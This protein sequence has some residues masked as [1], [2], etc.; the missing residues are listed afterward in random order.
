LDKAWR[1]GRLLNC[2]DVHLLAVVPFD[3]WANFKEGSNANKVLVLARSWF[4]AAS[5]DH[6][7]L[8]AIAFDAD[9]G[10]FPNL[11][12]LFLG[13]KTCTSR[14]IHLLLGVQDDVPKTCKFGGLSS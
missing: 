8:H 3:L 12:Q 1:N 10:F 4:L 14:F 11:P 5:A 9:A 2:C 6:M 7:H 13:N